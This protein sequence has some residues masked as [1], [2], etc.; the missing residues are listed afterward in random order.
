LQ[1]F[2]GTLIFISH[3]V[4]FIRTLANHV[5]RVENGRL[6]HFTGGYQYYLDKTSQSARAALTSSHSDSGGAGSPNLK[7][8]TGRRGT[9]PADGAP[10]MDRK[11]QKRMEAE[12]RQ[13]RSRKKQE[14]QKR[15][16]ALEKEI[17][18]LETREKELTAELE[19]PE[20]Y[21]ACGRAT[22][23]NREL[24]EVHDRLAGANTEW[25][26]AGTELAQFEAD[27]AAP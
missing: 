24:M 16:A 9:L 6:R 2:E 10:V 15:L 4:H 20:T 14:I 26:S 11:G 3:D 21:A 22:Q 12:Q 17:A 7:N 18:A 27:S 8:Q 13:A 19:K 23:I 25:E 1:P 5:V